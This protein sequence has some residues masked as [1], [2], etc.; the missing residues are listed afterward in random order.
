M[1]IRSKNFESWFK[2]NL[3][4]YAQDIAQHGADG[5]FPCITYT[6]DTVKIFD[7]FA[8]EIWQMGVEDA[9]DIGYNNIAAMIAEF[10]RSDMLATLDSFKSLMVWYACEKLARQITES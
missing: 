4:P 6:N 8:S 10:G 3:R 5:G 9:Q 1:I 2:A 7:K